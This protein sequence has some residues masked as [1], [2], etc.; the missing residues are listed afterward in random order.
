MK[1]QYSNI[2]VALLFFTVG[3]GLGIV[4]GGS[5]GYNT[6]YRDGCTYEKEHSDTVKIYKVIPIKKTEEY[7]KCY[8]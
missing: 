8:D 7:T 1:K 6:G 4:I 5:M 3:I 2:A